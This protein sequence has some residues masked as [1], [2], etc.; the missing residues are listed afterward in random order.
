VIFVQLCNQQLRF[1]KQ[2]C[3]AIHHQVQC[4]FEGDICVSVGHSDGES[5]GPIDQDHN[6]RWQPTGCIIGLRSF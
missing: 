3:F 5:N 6:E 2:T 4:Q 1:D